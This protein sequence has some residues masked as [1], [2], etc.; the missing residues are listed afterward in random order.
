MAT[1][2]CYPSVPTIPGI[3]IIFTLTLARAKTTASVASQGEVLYGQSTSPTG[4]SNQRSEVKEHDRAQQQERE[5]MI[6]KEH[7]E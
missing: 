5:V 4:S 7:C 3:S 6:E 1:S 2:P